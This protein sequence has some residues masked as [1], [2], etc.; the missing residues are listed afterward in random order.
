MVHEWTFIFKHHGSYPLEC[1]VLDLGSAW[2]TF[3]LAGSV[4]MAVMVLGSSWGNLERFQE[5]C[6]C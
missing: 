3:C 6:F 2:V 1:P 5:S 4:I